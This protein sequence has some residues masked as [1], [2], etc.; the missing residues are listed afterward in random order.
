M[1][2]RKC[3]MYFTKIH[4]TAPRRDAIK[5]IINPLQSNK[6]CLKA[7]IRETYN[8]ALQ[9][10]AGEIFHGMLCVVT[11]KYSWVPVT[12]VEIW[13]ALFC[14]FYADFPFGSRTSMVMGLR[15][16]QIFSADLN[17]A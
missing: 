15:Y 8:E 7:H 14:D 12:Y 4:W 1:L 3:G 2:L 13:N 6:K 16:P 5:I 17:A 10:E 11:K 9:T